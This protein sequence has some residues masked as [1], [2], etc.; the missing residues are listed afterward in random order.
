MARVYP[1]ETRIQT[2]SYNYYGQPIGGHDNILVRRKVEEP[3][4]TLHPGNAKLALQRH[5][6]AAAA[7]DYGKLNYNQRHWWDK[8]LEYAPS[9][10]LLSGQSLYISKHLHNQIVHA[11]KDDHSIIQPETRLAPCVV[12]TTPGGVLLDS[13]NCIIFNHGGTPEII[14]GEWIAMGNFIFPDFPDKIGDGVLAG[15]SLD[16]PAWSSPHIHTYHDL[17]TVHYCYASEQCYVNFYSCFMHISLGGNPLYP[18]GENCENAGD[19]VY[20]YVPYGDDCFSLGLHELYDK[21]GMTGY[22]LGHYHCPKCTTMEVL[23]AGHGTR[24]FIYVR[25][26]NEGEYDITCLPI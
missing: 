17:A 7:A 23:G 11:D 16:W 12:T 2:S 22:A 24:R 15:G 18:G 14:S 13:A 10:K 6:L 3:C 21:D 26:D 5:R 1:G 25:R 20:M 8:R 4:D 19:Y 9:G